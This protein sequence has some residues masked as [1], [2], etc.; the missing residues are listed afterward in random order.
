MY[1]VWINDGKNPKPPDE[2]FYEIAANGIFLHKQMPFWKAVVPVDRI[3]TLEEGAPDFESYLPP[4]PKGLVLKAARF[5]AWICREHDSE[6]IVLIYQN[7]TDKR[8]FMMA[9]KQ[10]V[11]PAKIDYEFPKLDL[12]PGWVMVGTMHSHGKLSA[13]HSGT[14]LHDEASLNGI[15]VTFGSF[16]RWNRTGPISVSVEAAVNG[17]RFPLRVEDVMRGLKREGAEPRTFGE[18]ITREA[19]MREGSAWGRSDSSDRMFTLEG[20]EELLPVDY[21]PPPTWLVQVT[22]RSFFSRVVTREVKD[23]EGVVRNM[24]SEEAR[25]WALAFRD[26]RNRENQAKK[27]AVA[28]KP[29][30][31]GK[32]VI[33]IQK[34]VY[35]EGGT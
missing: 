8:F 33:P 19:P 16:P 29:A 28:D 3:S 15:H 21:S 9:P 24:T 22:T 12:G 25:K 2:I 10:T 34:K 20:E 1:P 4:F 35:R 17:Y 32:P 6:A 31:A 27:P 13:F 14:D 18:A 11:S 7:E 5:F 30:T 26:K 23:A